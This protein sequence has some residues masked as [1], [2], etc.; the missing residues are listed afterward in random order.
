MLEKLG[1]PV[2]PKTNDLRAPTEGGLI[3]VAEPDGARDGVCNETG[4]NQLLLAPKRAGRAAE[5]VRLAAWLHWATGSPTPFPR[6][7]YEAKRAPESGG[8]Q[9]ATCVRVDKV[10]NWTDQRVPATAGVQARRCS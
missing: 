10:E 5:M 1:V 4:L 2:D 7:T 9:M 3:I 8:R 6:S